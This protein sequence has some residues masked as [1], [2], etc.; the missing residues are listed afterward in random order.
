[1]GRLASCLSWT[2][3]LILLLSR[4]PAAHA[5]D[6]GPTKGV[7]GGHDASVAALDAGPKEAEG[8]D[9]GP[10]LAERAATLRATLANLLLVLDGKVPTDGYIEDLFPFDL[11]DEKAVEAARKVL[12][13][14]IATWKERLKDIRTVSDAVPRDAG[15][16]AQAAKDG[17]G[18]KGA[19]TREES[20]PDAG[21]VDA[22]VDAPGKDA[23]L[24]EP[25]DEATVLGLEV[26]LAG[27]RRAFLELPR[28]QRRALIEQDAERKR[29]AFEKERANAEREKALAEQRRAETARQKALEEAERARDEMERVVAN[30]HARMEG[31]RGAQAIYRRELAERRQAWAAQSSAQQERASAIIDRAARV[32]PAS[33]EANTMYDDI[34]AELTTLRGQVREGLGAYRQAP[35]AARYTPDTTF[36]AIRSKLAEKDRSAVETSVR[37]LSESATDLERQARALAWDTLEASVSKERELNAKRVELLDVISPAKRGD[38]LGFGPEGIAQFRR[39]LDR[40]ALE[41]AWY[42]AHGEVRIRELKDL[43]SNPFWIGQV[44]WTALLLLGVLGA[45]IYVRRKG[46]NALESLRVGIVR[47]IRRPSFA[48][49]VAAIIDA[50][51]AVLPPLVFV[52]G[53]LGAERA[54]GRTAELVEFSVPLRLM[55]WY[56]SYRLFIVASHRLLYRAISRGAK[57]GPLGTASRRSGLVARSVRMVARYGFSV[58]IML[59]VAAEVL[60]KGYLY[61]LVLRFAWLGAFPI[62][63]VLVRRWRGDIAD[64]YLAH[65]TEGRLADLV[66]STRDR[67]FGF[68][69]AVA[70][71]AVVLGQV[72]L[73]AARRFVLGFEQT[74]KALAFLFRR[75]LEKQAAE[76]TSAPTEEQLPED[77]RAWFSED[78]VAEETYAITDLLGMDRFETERDRWAQGKKSTALIVVGETGFG[79]TSWLNAAEARA[80]GPVRRVTLGR[81][82]VREDDFLAFLARELEL[83]AS[84]PATRSTVIDAIAKAE[85]QVILVDEAHHLTLRGVGTLGA[86]DA[87][88]DIVEQTRHNTLWVAAMNGFAFQHLAWVRGGV[89]PFREKIHLR[90]WSEARVGL[91]LDS[92]SRESGY[93]MVYDDL[94]VDK[95][96]G[97]QGEAQLVSTQEGYARLIWDYADGCPRVAL[98]CWKNSLVPDGPKRVRVRLFRRPK[99]DELESLDDTERFVLASV[100][101]HGSLTRDEAVTSLNL[102]LPV[103]EDAFD[104][105]HDRGVLEERE[106]RF[107]IVT[108]WLCPVLRFL[109]R[110]HLIED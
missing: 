62:F 59:I 78:P 93:E 33:A 36:D 42:R 85:R 20:T 46:P 60:G 79:K 15:V 47:S 91:L 95:L 17:R 110:K 14:D 41:G 53:V 90:S 71:F 87:F 55:L 102:S 86:W 97:V 18:P 7:D 25:V 56:A 37:D 84:E 51:V 94:V 45:V 65:R 28:D 13:E 12:T 1:M 69:V 76:V 38:V 16:D 22:A 57:D 2:T 19:G 104:K 29:V 89:E 103:C 96:E 6:A 50:L 101:W 54:L 74:R 58:A 106:G 11:R 27:A 61:H 64:A 99:A 73:R 98:H 75:R 81:R 77:L 5:A 23:G 109:R 49:P 40:M 108:R 92:R 66:R 105:L 4:L 21:I 44:T 32:A 48:R 34:V 88:A 43:S 9:A 8:S 107:R 68:F 24:E 83:D 80:N 100:V 82:I 35:P 67:W 63:F 31:A 3:V 72:S 30:E 70:A 52:L 26:E 10:T 39:E